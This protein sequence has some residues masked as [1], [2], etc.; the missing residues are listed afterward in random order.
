MRFGVP[1]AVI[2][3]DGLRFRNQSFKAMIAKYKMTCK[4]ATDVHTCY[5]YFCIIHVQHNNIFRIVL[6]ILAH[7]LFI[8]KSKRFIEIYYFMSICDI[9]RDNSSGETDST[10]REWKHISIAGIRHWMKKWWRSKEFEK[11]WQW[12]NA[13]K[14]LEDLEDISKR[15]H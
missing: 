8:V 13:S 7:I 3:N 4:V 15:P 12:K 11:R 5:T 14:Q 2:S 6:V 10:K 9:Y 1:W